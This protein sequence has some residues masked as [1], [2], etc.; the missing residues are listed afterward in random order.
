M[1]LLGLMPFLLCT[2]NWCVLQCMFNDHSSEE[3][4]KLADL[5]FETAHL[6]S[7]FTVSME[8]VVF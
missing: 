4:E 3:A 8:A 2:L 7:G 5:L 1:H 6:S